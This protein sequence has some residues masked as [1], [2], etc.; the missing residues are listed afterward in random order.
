M[1][2]VN[3]DT[4]LVSSHVAAN[5]PF[6]GIVVSESEHPVYAACF[7][8][9]LG[10]SKNQ[11]W[12]CTPNSVLSPGLLKQLTYNKTK[13]T[14]NAPPCVLMQ[15]LSQKGSQNVPEVRSRGRG[16]KSDSNSVFIL[17][18]GVMIC[19]ARQIPRLQASRHSCETI[20]IRGLS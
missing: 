12:S 2:P 6:L 15:Q 3:N 5:K 4:K 14:H 11:V 20:Q 19:I 18:M 17:S 10:R 8:V 13:I 16:E 7:G 9:T 1:S